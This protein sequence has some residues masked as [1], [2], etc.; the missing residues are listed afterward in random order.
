MEGSGPL[1]GQNLTNAREM[2]AYTSWLPFSGDP[3]NPGEIDAWENR[4][5]AMGGIR[6]QLREAAGGFLTEGNLDRAINAERNQWSDALLGKLMGGEYDLGKE[7]AER[8]KRAKEEFAMNRGDIN[9]NPAA[10]NPKFDEAWASR[11]MSQQ[12]MA[13]MALDDQRALAMAAGEIPWDTK[14]SGMAVPI[15]WHTLARRMGQNMGSPWAAAR[16]W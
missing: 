4:N 14:P 11:P 3:T 1:R 12:Q 9:R 5:A 15:S 16:R 7:G 13:R 8:Y 6:D 10:R 2:M